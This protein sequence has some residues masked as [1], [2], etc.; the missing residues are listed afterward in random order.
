[1]VISL[2]SRLNYGTLF[3][4]RADAGAPSKNIIKTLH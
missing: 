1:M 3:A 4:G 2:H